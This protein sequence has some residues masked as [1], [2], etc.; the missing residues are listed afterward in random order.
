[1]SD[2]SPALDLGLAMNID[3]IRKFVSLQGKTVIDAGCGDMTVAKMLAGE[4]AT[5]LALDPDPI[6]AEKNRDEDP[7]PGIQFVETTAEQ[8]PMDDG[9][10]DGAFFSYSL[11]HIPVETYPQVFAEVLRVLKPTGFIYVIEPTD[12]PLN[13]VM[14]HFHDEEEVRAA[15]QHALIELA[16]QSFDSKQIVDYHSIRTFESF[17]EFATHFSSRSFNTIYSEADVRAPQVE[18]AFELHG[19]PDYQFVAPKRVVI[20]KDRKTTSV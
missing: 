7:I 13:Q 5:V 2:E 1:M 19:A 3:V 6:Q 20:L 15:A 17:E 10:V 12:C 4:G 9:S 11:H 8:I 16:A 14:M 18:Q